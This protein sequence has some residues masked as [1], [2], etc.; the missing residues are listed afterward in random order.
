MAKRPHAKRPNILLLMVDQLAPQALPFHGHP[1]VQAPNLEALSRRA[2][3]FERAYCNFPICAPSRMSMLAG[4]LPHALDAF[5]NA[6]EFPA[7]VPTVAHY[8]AWLGYRTILCGKMHFIGPDQRHGFEERLTTDI[9]PSDFSWTAD[10]LR[11]PAY[12]P[13]GVSMRPVIEAGPCVR[14]L[15]IDYDD[16]VEYHGIQK[17]YDLARS[18]DDR[19]FFLTISLTHPHPPFVSPREHWDRYRH[20]EIDMP[21]VAPIAPADLDEHSRWLRLAHAQDDYTVTDEHIRNARHAYYGM[22][23]YVDDKI[24]RILTTL[25][26][27]GLSDDTV[28]LFVGDHGEMLGER[29]MWFKQTF[30]EWSARVPM[31]ISAPGIAP[32]RVGAPVSLVDLMPTLLDLATDGHPPETVDPCDGRSLVDLMDGH[33]QGADRIVISEYSSE[34]V[35]AASRM[36]RDRRHKYIHTRGLPPMLFDL[37][38]DPDE[39]SNLASRPESADLLQRFASLATRDW[40]PERVHQRILASQKRRLFLAEA[41]RRTPGY[42]NWA[43]QPFVDE[44]RRYVRGGG[45]DG[46]TGTKGRARFPYVEPAPSNPARSS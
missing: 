24:G 14:S 16:E 11:G 30:F 36:V 9:Y 37:E 40:D 28:I 10:F 8:L 6:S 38:A 13:T 21:R 42:P 26:D 43:Y 3:V 22:V 44:S 35:C 1:L 41:A 39:L 2:V 19:P 29:G 12:R 33:D 23:S 34:G 17:I 45:S 18:E 46:P 27:C 32:R 15:Q 4:R 5:D 31:M 7:S 20:D 25:K